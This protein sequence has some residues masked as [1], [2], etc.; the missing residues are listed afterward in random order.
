MPGEHA[1][2]SPSA[3]ARWS[4]CHLSIDMDDTL[5]DTTSV[6]A[7]RGTALHAEAEAHLRKGTNTD[8]LGGEDAEIVQT[9]IDYIRSLAHG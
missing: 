9:Y 6:Y 1:K 3:Y 2:L 7:D 5:P 8:P 4:V